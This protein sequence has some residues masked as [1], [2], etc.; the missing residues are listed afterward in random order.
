MTYKKTI[1]QIDQGPRKK[2]GDDGILKR[3]SGS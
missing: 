2:P 3:V 1:N